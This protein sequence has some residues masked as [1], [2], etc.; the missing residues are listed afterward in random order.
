MSALYNAASVNA[1]T[2]LQR[3][4]DAICCELSSGEK[5][6]VIEE[7]NDFLENEMGDLEADE[8]E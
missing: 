3:A 7:M 6:A 4:Y 2:Q 8:E 1:F 5:R